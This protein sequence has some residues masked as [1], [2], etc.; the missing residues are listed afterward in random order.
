MLN[1]T[2]TA[3]RRG[4][5]KPGSPV[6]FRQVNVGEVKG[7]EL[8]KTAE[9]VDIYVSIQKRYAPLIRENTRFWIT[10]GVQC[11]LF[12]GLKTESIESVLA[13][14]IAFA[15]PDN[16]QMGPRAKKTSRFILHE[17]PMEV[18]LYWKPKIDLVL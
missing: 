18:W 16:G 8:S 1:I 5:L 15:T 13:G 12:T 11:G 4:S 2:L 10:S 14:G 3:D 7:Y 17:K 9:G 6:S